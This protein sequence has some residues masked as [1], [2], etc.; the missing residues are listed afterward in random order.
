MHSILKKKGLSNQHQIDY[1]KL[2]KK[3]S[4][5]DLQNIF[6]SVFEQEVFSVLKKMCLK[7]SSCWSK[8][9]VTAVLDDSVF[10]MWLKND[11]LLLDFDNCYGRFFSGQFGKVVSGAKILTFGLS[12][13][14]VFYPMY[15]D[16]V[17]KSTDSIP[18]VE[19]ATEVA[20]RIVKKWHKFVQD[21]LQKGVFI[22]KINFSCDS[23]Y[24]DVTLSKVVDNCSL[25]YISVPKKSHIIEIYNRNGTKITIK[26]S[27][28]IEKKF[29]QAEK[30][31]KKKSS[32][33]FTFRFR[34]KYCNQNRTVTFLAFRFNGSEKVSIIYT[35]N[36]NIHEKTLRKHWFQRTYIEQFFKLLKHVMQIQEARPSGKTDFFFKICRY[37]FVALHAQLLIKKLRLH[38]FWN[39][40]DGF[41]T[42]QRTLNDD[43]DLHNLLHDLL[44][45]KN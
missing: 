16:F 20:Q 25:N 39:K 5:N 42:L 45:I 24:N 6:S 34:A 11:Q 35:T 38:S 15:F 36:K 26:L 8:T 9:L 32:E 7:D 28:W 18:K 29:I 30:R 4:I 2:C 14:G 21:A 3:L 22:P 19:K 43:P 41:I 33:P 40:K 23:G 10:R 31:H 44:G 27:V 13:N 17:K 37:A 12:I 1:C